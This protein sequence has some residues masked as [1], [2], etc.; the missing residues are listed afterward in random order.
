M[1]ME[2]IW[3]D[4]ANAIVVRAVEDYRDARWKVRNFPDQ[5]EARA[6][7]VD[8]E[9]FLLSPWYEMLTNVDGEWLLNRL[10]EEVVCRSRR[11]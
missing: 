9:E 2:K 3:E 10:K 4:L 11:I 7:I 1:R 6:T 8:V 5:F